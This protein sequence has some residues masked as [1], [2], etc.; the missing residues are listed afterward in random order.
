MCSTF[1]FGIE[2]H[3]HKSYGMEVQSVSQAQSPLRFAQKC[4][5]CLFLHTRT[6]DLVRAKQNALVPIASHS[7][8]SQGPGVQAS[9]GNFKPKV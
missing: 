5:E 1:S 2:V 4:L 8:W 9:L 3:L 6:W 7:H